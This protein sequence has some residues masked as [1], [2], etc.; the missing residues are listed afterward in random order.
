MKILTGTIFAGTA[1]LLSACGHQ[2]AYK[3]DGTPYANRTAGEGEVVRYVDMNERQLNNNQ[4]R[5]RSYESTF[6]ETLRK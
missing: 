1:L 5:T 6:R 2:T 4:M 3:Y